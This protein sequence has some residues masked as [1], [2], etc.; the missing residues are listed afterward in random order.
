MSNSI[1]DWI[2]V[3]ALPRVSPSALCQL[4]QQGWTPYKLLRESESTLTSVGFKPQARNAILAYQLQQGPLWQRCQ[5]VLAWQAENHAQ[6]HIIPFDSPD[7]SPLLKQIPDPPPFLML[8]GDPTVLARPQVAIVGSRH[9]TRQGLR[10]AA[11]FARE[12]SQAGLVVTSGMALG[13]DGAAHQAVVDQQM[14]TLAVFGT[15]P[16]LLYPARHRRLAQ[17]I[18]DQGGALVSEFWPGTPPKGGHFPRRNRI[19]SGLCAGI[20]V[21]EAA[22]R[23]GSLITA[24]LALDYN[25]EVFA[26]PGALHS[27]QSQGCHE[28]IR[29]GAT[30]VQTTDHIMEQLAALLGVSFTAETVDENLPPPTAELSSDEQSL[31]SVMEYEQLTLDQLSGLTGLAI[32]DL[33]QQLIGLELKGLVEAVGVGYQRTG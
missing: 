3:A 16:D 5:Q 33:T 17:Q 14:P 27:P 22:P 2:A 11:V 30:L 7:Y 20:L 25:R 23:S 10:H 4:W 12:L 9:A 24:R 21:I 31:L 13:V 29:Q 8:R 15:G 6:H 26:L 18:L 1:H 19:I 32:P 28:L